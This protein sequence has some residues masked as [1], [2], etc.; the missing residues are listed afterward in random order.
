MTKFIPQIH[1]SNA[2]TIKL[3]PTEEIINDADGLRR[4]CEQ[5]DAC[6]LGGSLYFAGSHALKGWCDDVT[7]VHFYRYLRQSTRYQAAE[8]ALKYNPDVKR[9]VGHSLG[10][11][12]ALDMQKQSP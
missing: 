5:G 10:C 7:K 9:V 3:E 1:N 2:Q 12:V 4:A 8:K 11:S 6:R